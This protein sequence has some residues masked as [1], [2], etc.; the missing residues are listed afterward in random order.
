MFFSKHQ[1][2]SIH[3]K[4]HVLCGSQSYIGSRDGWNMLSQ[5]LS[6]TFGIS[7]VPSYRKLQRKENI[8]SICLSGGT[9]G[10]NAGIERQ[11]YKKQRQQ[12][13]ELDTSHLKLQNCT[14]PGGSPFHTDCWLA[15]IIPE[16]QSA[17]DFLVYLILQKAKYR[18]WFILKL[19]VLKHQRKE[20]LNGS[21]YSS[22]HPDI[23]T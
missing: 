16:L 15:G 10:E 4:G 9:C 7:S 2:L 6:F 17:V 1:L 18:E 23:H 3:T 21:P 22:L 8:Q 11:K 19:S 5:F 14:T 13:R 20:L 12:R